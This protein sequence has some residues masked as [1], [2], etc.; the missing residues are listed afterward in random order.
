MIYLVLT[1]P[2]V[3]V[4]LFYAGYIL[5]RVFEREEDDN[6]YFASM[7]LLS[8]VVTTLIYVVVSSIIIFK[9]YMI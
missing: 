4:I 7:S 6:K 5:G 9:H 2:F 3:C 8:I 1:Y